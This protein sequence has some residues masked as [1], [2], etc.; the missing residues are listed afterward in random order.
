MTTAVT[1]KEMSTEGVGIG[2]MATENA[3]SR[4]G[5]SMYRLHRRVSKFFSHLSF[6]TRVISLRR[7]PSVQAR[8]IWATDASNAARF[9]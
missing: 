2:H 6:P 7:L 4:R 3:M 9:E 1:S 5:E 8:L